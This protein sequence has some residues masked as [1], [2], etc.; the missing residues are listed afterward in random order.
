[1]M[2]ED[3]VFGPIYSRR[4]GSSL[5]INI[6]PK[7]GKLC[8]F[9]CIY[10]ECGWNKDGEKDRLLPSA[11]DLKVYLE[12]KLQECARNSIKIDSITFSG[13]GEPTLNND[14][15]EMVDLTLA[16]RN[17]YYPDAKVSVLSNATMLGRKSV[18]EALLKV[19]NPILKIDAPTDEAIDIINKPVGL[20]KIED[21][22]KNLEKFKGNFVL[23]TMFLKNKNF[24][25]SSSKILN[26][27]MDIVRRLHP[28]EIMIYT[29]DRETPEKGIEKFTEEEM[30]ELVKP[31][32]QEKFNIRING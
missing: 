8:N 21:V 30:K 5:G 15:P 10:C 9:D 11:A 17:K 14:F 32:I 12:R 18:F 4:L 31:L 1:M 2:R 7:R 28:R 27:W 19:D 29:V 16:L 6:L 25:S 20:Y 22:V 13:D 26:P 23:Q 24:D 3:L